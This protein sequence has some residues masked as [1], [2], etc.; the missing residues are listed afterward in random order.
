MSH[1]TR[2]CRLTGWRQLP[3]LAEYHRTEGY[4]STSFC[5][6]LLFSCA[7]QSWGWLPRKNGIATMCMAPLARGEM[8]GKT[9]AWRQASSCTQL[10]FGRQVGCVISHSSPP[11]D[12]AAIAEELGVTEAA[13]AVRPLAW[14]FLRAQPMF[15]IAMGANS[16]GGGKRSSWFRN[17]KTMSCDV[18]RQDESLI[19]F[20]S[21]RLDWCIIILAWTLEHT[22]S[23]RLVH[24]NGL[25]SNPKA[26]CMQLP[27]VRSK[28]FVLPR[29]FH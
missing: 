12:V 21:I 18:M 7:L 9:D 20:D 15:G 28:R 5:S 2:H 24:A 10:M 4:R 8:F 25:Y 3:D 27:F 1:A 11:Q 19:C 16:W 29:P 17:S 6:L 23:R 26:H 22:A 13:V 14:I